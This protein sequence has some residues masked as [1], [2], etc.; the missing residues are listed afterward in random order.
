MRVMILEDDSWI[1][2]LLKQI[3]LSLRPN[4]QVVCL[5]NVSAALR[6]WQQ[7]PADMVICDWNLPDGPGTRLLE[8]VR[9]DNSSTPLVVITGRSDRASVL[10]VR[11]LKISAFISKPFQAAHVAASLATL[12]PADN[13]EQQHQASNTPQDLLNHLRSLP[14]SALQLPLKA[15]V[16]DRLL[17]RFKGEQID[18]RE[19]ASEWQHD[20][21]LSARLLA[22]ANSSAYNQAGNPCTNLLEALHK[23]GAINSL[24]LAMGLALRQCS[25]LD[26]A[27]LRLLAQAHLDSTELLIERS[28]SLARQCAMDPA[29]LHTAALLHR[30]GELCVLYLAQVWQDSGQSFSETQV[31]QALDQFS[32]PFAVSIKAQW[33]LPMQLRELIGAC[34]N[35][36]ANN[37]K[38]ENILMRLA[39]CE[40][41]NATDDPEL[42]R[43]R[44]LAGLS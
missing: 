27:L 36:P 33:H 17:Q 18:L 26:N 3:V 5:D 4:S 24:N 21:A 44:R 12:L 9:R 22:V 41:N 43:L 30:M 23:L 25:T 13:D 39:A 11:A 2:D 8:Q 1:A 35:L 15:H 37:V 7:R 42:A 10:A 16:R 20:P 19:L 28:T 14:S 40:L 32:G 34:Y 38:R 6:E 29:P 31:M